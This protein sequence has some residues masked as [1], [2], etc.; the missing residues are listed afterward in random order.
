MEDAAPCTAGAAKPRAQ[1]L[2]TSEGPFLFQL[3]KLGVAVEGD[4]HL[5][6]TQTA[7]ANRWVIFQE[8]VVLPLPSPSAT[9]S[10]SRD[11]RGESNPLFPRRQYIVMASKVSGCP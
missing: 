5:G 6:S 3:H 10:E 9:C 1:A 8:L 7:D 11:H 4:G 2:F